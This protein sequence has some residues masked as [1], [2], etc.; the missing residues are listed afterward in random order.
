MKNMISS[1]LMVFL[2]LSSCREA[3]VVDIKA[4][5]FE[6]DSAIVFGEHQD[7]MVSALPDSSLSLKYN[8]TDSSFQWKI[9]KPV[10]FKVENKTQNA[11]PLDSIR[12]IQ[13]GGTTFG[14]SRMRNLAAGFSAVD[15]GVKYI[16]LNNLVRAVD[17]VMGRRMEKFNSL[18]A[19]DEGGK[20]SQ[21]ILI[22]LDSDIR[23]T[24][25]D[26]QV[27]SFKG[28]DSLKASHMSL[29]FFRVFS[30][31]L[32]NPQ[33]NDFHIADTVYYAAV[34]SMYT[35]FGSSRLELRAGDKVRLLFNRYF[36][37]LIPKK[38]IDTTFRNNNNI[39]VSIRQQVQS[40]TY[41]NEIY[42]VNFSNSNAFDIGTVDSAMHFIR[43]K[44]N[45]LLT[46][47][48]LHFFNIGKF[49]FLYALL[50]LLAV[51]V[52]G[53]V[54]IRFVTN[55]SLYEGESN[56]GEN[57][58]WRKYFWILFTLLFVLGTGRV[59][60]GYN[61]S[62]TAPYYPFALPTASIIS[63]LVLLTV[64]YVWVI[65]IVINDPETLTL[66]FRLFLIG[67]VFAFLFAL[68][69]FAAAAFP[70][71]VA[72]FHDVFSWSKPFK[73][74]VYYLS[75]TT[76]SLFLCTVVASSLLLVK[77]A[78]YIFTAG[79]TGLGCAFFLQK[80]S[81][82]I[83]ALLI[84]IAL[85]NIIVMRWTRF[86]KLNFESGWLKKTGRFFLL[87]IPAV[88]VFA[89]AYGVK[90][91]GGYFINLL[92]FPLIMVVVIFGYY[93]FYPSADGEVDRNRTKK[94]WL[95]SIAAFIF[96][97]GAL[98]GLALSLSRN[99][100]P[101]QHDRM[102]NRF[103]SFFSFS[104]VHSYGTR[105]SE[106]QAQFFAELSKYAY[107]SAEAGYE[108]VHPGISSYIDP[109]VKNDL[110]V[111]F[112]L[113]Y[114]FGPRWFYVPVVLLILLWSGLLYA[115]LR[116]SVAPAGDSERRRYLTQAAIIRIYC[117]CVI[118]SSGLWLIASY[119]SVVPFTGRLIYGLGQDSIAEVF[120]TVFLFGYMG[121]IR[122]SKT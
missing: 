30:S 10:Y 120:E 11:V 38:V 63:A 93:R 115:V 51:F 28:E 99:Y 110:S 72:Q 20:E 91:D 26:G 121:L 108:P 14:F 12:T 48:D 83:S 25:L 43:D 92:L 31:V 45:P 24:R 118:V 50:P 113:I 109:V 13:V 54:I 42:T 88:I 77:K 46:D 53:M 5:Q 56:H 89:I 58:R 96:V 49:S 6:K 84:V 67:F 37:T 1:L 75:I 106:K 61:L 47:A 68:Y 3:S 2:L 39:A 95:V 101:L 87:L 94:E 80:S 76:L 107:P 55:D 122:K 52:F 22:L 86:I 90:H 97:A 66:K 21:P 100:D 98:T 57:T 104:S 32:L 34:K 85:L 71:Y 44:A 116:I 117:V 70:Y 40:N 82:S 119:Y 4:V 36:R 78:E 33:S 81:Y 64:L 79:C 29:E 27:V 73:N 35:P 23:V 8:A 9:L 112:G 41:S 17:T 74:E 102:H 15:D 65:F 7:I 62:Y 69:K 16:K 60:I 114:Q 59:F 111:P 19:C 105:E 103:T 18:V